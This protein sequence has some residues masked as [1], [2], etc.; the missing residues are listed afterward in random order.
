MLRKASADSILVKHNMSE[1]ANGSEA[2]IRNGLRL[3]NL[4]LAW[5]ERNPTTGPHSELIM[6][7]AA[8]RV[9]AVAGFI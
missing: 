1:I 4:V 5:S 8:T 7:P 9:P 6:L 2:A 3:P